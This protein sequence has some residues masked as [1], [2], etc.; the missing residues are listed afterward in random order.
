MEGGYR[1]DDTPV[2]KAIREALA[3]CLV[4]ADYYGRQGL[5]IIKEP[6]CL[7]LSNPGYFRI[8]VAA[9]KSGGISDPRNGT[10]LKMFNLIDIGERAGSGIPNIFRVWHDQGW[11]EPTIS[12]QMNPDRTTLTLV[13]SPMSADISAIKI[14]DKIG[15]KADDHRISDGPSCGKIRGDRSVCKPQ[16]LPGAG[17]PQGADDRG[18]CCSRRWEPEPDISAQGVAYVDE[19]YS[20]RKLQIG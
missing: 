4:N 7:R 18:Y 12:Q 6:G 11:A 19:R 17:L 15:E 3:N 13:L 16:A 10:L 14:G 5:V 8:E 1:G 2:H 9:A 20:T